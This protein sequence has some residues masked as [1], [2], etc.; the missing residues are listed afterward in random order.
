MSNRYQPIFYDYSAGLDELPERNTKSAAISF[1]AQ[2]AANFGGCA[3]VYD[4]QARRLVWAM[5]EFP[6]YL[7]TES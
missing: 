1:A 5:P 2:Y 3:A 4:H 6:R 7:V